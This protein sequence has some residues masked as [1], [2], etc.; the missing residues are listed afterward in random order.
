MAT[1]VG[2]TPAPLNDLVPIPLHL[3][4]PHTIMLFD[5]LAAL[6]QA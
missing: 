1:I 3:I 2:K 6:I 4:L 5:A